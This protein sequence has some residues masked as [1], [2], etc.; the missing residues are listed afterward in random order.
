MKKI[1]LIG[2]TLISIGII[3][4]YLSADEINTGRFNNIA[5]G[6]YDPV[7]YHLLG[8]P[9]KGSADFSIIWKGAEWPFLS[10]EYLDIFESDPETYVPQFGGFCAN[11]LSDG[12]KIRGN[13]KIWRVYDGQLFLFYS[14]RGRE[15]WDSD[16][17]EKIQLASDYWEEV[18]YN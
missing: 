5:I 1:I 7:A 9:Q 12:H 17:E 15:S 10:Q 2:I 13:P 14:K 6:G 16:T 18:Q 8:S 4:S 3:G 11:G